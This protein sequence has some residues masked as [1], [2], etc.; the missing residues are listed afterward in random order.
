MTNQNPESTP[1]NEESQV[2]DAQAA[3]TEATEQEQNAQAG[4]APAQE[5]S[6]EAN[7]APA[8][9]ESNDEKPAAAKAEADDDDEESFDGNQQSFEELLEQYDQF[10]EYRPGEVVH[11]TVVNIGEQE[12]VF[13][14]GARVEGI[15][16]ERLIG[17]EH[18]WEGADSMT[19]TQTMHA[20]KALMEEHADAFIALPG[21]FGTLE[22]IAEFVTLKIL[23]YH[24][25]PLVMAPASYWQPLKAVF[26]HFISEDFASPNYA[27]L[28]DF[29]DT[30]LQAL[31]L[32]GDTSTPSD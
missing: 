3:S 1:A 19:Q 28:Y 10:R 25:E 4:E 15:I 7:A 13:D 30:P 6:V 29:A 9:A 20:R 27:G 22:E 2:Q 24:D 23:G 17:T 26:D 32:C 5:E 31:A 12:V 21:G 16:P 14:I 11:G 8:P 18:A